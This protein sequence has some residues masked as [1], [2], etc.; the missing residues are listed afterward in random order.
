MKPTELTLAILSAAAI[1]LDM[2][3]VPGA[4]IAMILLLSLLSVF[5]FCS[6]FL[7]FNSIR[8]RE[9]TKKDRFKGISAGRILGAVGTGV[10]L[11]YAIIGILFE[12]RIWPGAGITQINGLVLLA[13]VTIVGLFKY[14]RNKSPY[15]TRIFKRVAI[16]GGLVLILLVTPSTTWL[17]FKYRNH[18]AYLE[19]LTQ[20]LADPGNEELWMKV[21]EEREKMR[22]T[23][24]R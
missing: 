10:A 1:V 5:Y 16:I 6:G 12:L 24:S 3:L 22:D 23:Q 7:L 21:D 15:Y 4:G 9:V 2:F 8:L 17:A 13:V 19:A 18:P 11:S 14:A 20:A